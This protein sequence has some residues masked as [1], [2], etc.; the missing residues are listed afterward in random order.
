MTN[1]NNPIGSVWNKWDLHIH[2]PASFLWKGGKKLIEMNDAEKEESIKAFI[3]AVNES[4]CV[5]FG[6]MDYWTFDWF[7]ELTTYLKKHPD[8]LKKTIFPGMEL[9]VECPVD[10]RLNIHVLLS[11]YITKQQL[12]D[13]K[14]KLQIR[15][16]AQNKN[17]SNNA[18][19]EFGR[20]L[21]KDKAEKHGFNDPNTLNDTELSQLGSMTAEVTK[22]SLIDSFKQI[23]KNSG[24]IVLPYD[25]SDGL[26]DLDWSKHP[27]DDNFFMQ[28]AHIFEA[29]DQRNIDLFCGIKT[30]LNKEFFENFYKTLG[31]K[32]KPCIS[33]S[34]AHSFS[35]YGKFPS[36]KITWI[37]ADPTF[38]GFKQI[39]YEPIDRVRVQTNN[40]FDDKTK[41]FFRSFEITGSTHYIIPDVQIPFN[42]ELV[43]IIGGRGS[44]K[45]ALLDTFAFLNE[46]HLKSDRNGKKKIIEYYR[47]N[48]GKLVPAPNFTLKTNLIDKDGKNTEISK[49]LTNKTQ[50]E[51]PFLY[52]G[53][54]SLSSI[55]TNDFELT[56]TICDLVG[57]D[58]N[59]IK[60]QDLISRARSTLSEITNVEKQIEDLI[61]KYKTI[62]YTNDVTI[63]NWLKDYLI[64][65]T[66]QQKRLSSKET[67]KILEDINKD[68]E[69]GLRLKDLKEKSEFLILQ[70]QNNELNIEIQKF[71]L[72]LQKSYPGYKQ[73]N[74]IDT[75]KL[76]TDLEKVKTK[77][78][79]DMDILRKTI[80]DKKLKLIKQ[81]IKEDV[82]TL[83]Q[84]SEN[85]QR[86]ISN[87]QKEF[88]SY[89]QCIKT[90]KILYSDR[91]NILEEIIKVT[92]NVKNAITEAYAKFQL[93]RDDSSI[94]ETELFK[95]II[96]G[97]GVEG[98]VEFDV[99]GFSQYVMQNYVDN[100][101]IPNETELKKSIAGEKDDGTP[102][103][104]TF[105]IIMN[106][107]QSDL[108]NQ[109][110][111]SK[112]GLDGI[113]EYIFT[114]WPSFL[115]VR[116][117][118]KLNNQPTD[119][120]S[121]GQRGTLL[122]KVYLATASA[123]QVFII[124][125]PEDNLDNNF[126][127]NELVP[128]IR[129]TKKS[130]Q[131]IMS[132]HNANLVVNTDAEQVIVARLD[133]QNNYLSGGLENPVII[134]NVCEIL[135][136]GETAFKKREQ[137][138]QIKS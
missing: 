134:S 60:Q 43:T 96:D 113:T 71:N 137:K 127:M 86:Q 105:R 50:M 36:G 77:T 125:Q 100:R 128:L 14:S 73:I 56:K 59:E 111:F 65:L 44:G 104:L 47:S 55:A 28:T 2:T 95:K 76:T 124:D 22:D 85:L 1:Q 118:A 45:S 102:I 88:S 26:L 23:P 25:T 37:K 40:P 74:V 58:T 81:G 114:Q 18:L 34:D 8:E 53:Q 68:T 70:L 110:Y 101:R 72:D 16:G 89:E 106:W 21:S 115:K 94:E 20:S 6:V 91:K 46:E 24:F 121:I 112:G 87:V 79:S 29:R 107:I 30:D 66:E 84:A 75:G 10:Y 83:L 27:Q 63:E 9:R 67:R 123:K 42:R 82:N 135:E 48:E 126:I 138:Y 19:I 3:V 130:R 39:T 109:K 33:G 90:I 54:E 5:A 120:L 41:I 78:V 12:I 51:L 99:K 108:T 17:L 31:S 97:V 92:E 11:N 35:D 4:D 116:A 103:E 80:S 13:F 136:G 132:T 7:I 32:P 49:E 119:V 15:I 133:H 64:K 61:N 129:R 98:V 38:E 57:I 62:G 122:L 93:S 131:I 52:L 117:I 69:N